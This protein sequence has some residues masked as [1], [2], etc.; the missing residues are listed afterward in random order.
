MPEQSKRRRT[1]RIRRAK[2]SGGNGLSVKGLP[3]WAAHMAPAFEAPRVF[4]IAGSEGM[5]YTEDTIVA[6]EVMHMIAS[7]WSGLTQQFCPLEIEAAKALLRFRGSDEE[8]ESDAYE[9]VLALCVSPAGQIEGFALIHLNDAEDGI[10]MDIL[11]AGREGVVADA[12]R[13][14]VA[15]ILEDAIEEYDEEAFDED[16]ESDDE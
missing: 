3:M 12:K 4:F 8:S 16:E 14:M 1:R 2:Q 15:R 9:R 7:S 13:E 5:K 11:C 6:P 10:E